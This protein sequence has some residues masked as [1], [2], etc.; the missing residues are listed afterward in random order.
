M[1]G[2][3]IFRGVEFIIL[4]VYICISFEHARVLFL[5]QYVLD[6]VAEKNKYG[7]LYSDYMIGENFDFIFFFVGFV[8]VSDGFFIYNIVIAARRSLSVI[9]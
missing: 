8:F 4:C 9:F 3:E 6:P 1:I 2:I 5:R 7:H